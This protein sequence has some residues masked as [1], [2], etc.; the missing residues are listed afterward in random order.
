MYPANLDYRSLLADIEGLV[1]AH[2]GVDTV[3]LGLPSSQL[4]GS[5]G[6]L[7]SSPSD[8]SRASKKGKG[9]ELLTLEIGAAAAVAP[10][11]FEILEALLEGDPPPILI[12]R[13][14]GAGGK[15]GKGSRNS[16]SANEASEE[17]GMGFV[18]AV[19]LAKAAQVAEETAAQAAAARVQR[20]VAREASAHALL[21]QLEMRADEAFRAHEMRV[22]TA[23][24][25]NTA[26]SLDASTQ[27]LRQLQAQ[28]G[29]VYEQIRAEHAQ[30]L[31]LRAQIEARS[32]PT[33]T[34][35]AL[36]A[37]SML[38]GALKTARSSIILA[39]AAH[40]GGGEG[41]IDPEGANDPESISP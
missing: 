6:G 10:T 13:G 38:D 15:E 40:D 39:A 17:G 16:A 3:G 35:A 32:A 8:H 2:S 18:D 36:R 41:A 20:Q 23:A 7:V 22:W 4:L 12:A 5:L 34:A 37:E 9:F 24:H 29:Q 31:Q 21:L 11:D 28:L 27:R 14:A 25:P 30:T 19:A 1:P 33:T 26:R